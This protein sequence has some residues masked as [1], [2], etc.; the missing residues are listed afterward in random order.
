MGFIPSCRLHVFGLALG[1]ASC[2]AGQEPPDR[3]LAADI[4]LG[5]EST[6][7]RGTGAGATRRSRACSG[8]QSVARAD[9]DGDRR[10]A[11]RLQSA[12]PARQ[13]VVPADAHARR[14]VPRVPLHDRRR[15]AAARRAHGAG[16]GRAGRAMS[17]SCR[18]RKRSKWPRWPP[19]SAARTRRSSA[20]STRSGENIQL[21]LQLAEIFGGEVDFNSDLQPGDRID[22]LFERQT[23]DGEFVGYGEIKAAVLA[24]RRPASDRVP[25]SRQR[26]QARR[27]TTSRAGR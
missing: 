7:R 17:K 22:V 6:H 4:A 14:P 16:G 20:R 24:Q 2:V 3:A 26:R 10:R 25:L 15:P 9:D 12:R 13:P 23:R 18:C 19:R 5:R 27:G 8:I 11:R 1:L 21:P